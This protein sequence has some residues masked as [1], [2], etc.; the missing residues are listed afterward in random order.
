[1]TIDTV[2]LDQH[3]VEALDR[4]KVDETWFKEFLLPSDQKSI[5]RTVVED[6]VY[7]LSNHA[8]ED[9]KLLVINVRDTDGINTPNRPD[10]VL[11]RIVR[12][13]LNTFNNLVGIPRN[14]KLHR[15]GKLSSIF[16]YHF[17]IHD[18][19][20]IHF[21]RT[22]GGHLFV[23]AMTATTVDIQDVQNPSALYNQA[24]GEYENALLHTL[25]SDESKSD[26]SAP[27]D[28][29]GI[30]FD[31]YV[32]I[33]YVQE[34]TIKEWY[35]RRLTAQQRKFVDADLAKPIRLRGSAGTGKTQCLAIK[36]LKELFQ[37]EDEGRQL[38]VAFITHSAG[39]AHDAVRGMMAAL[40]PEGRLDALRYAELWL[41]SLYELA[42]KLL[43]YEN[44]QIL[45]ISL[46]GVEGRREQEEWLELCI[47][48]CVSDM[49]FGNVILPKCSPHVRR[50][51][52]ASPIDRR[53]LREMANE[54]ACVLDANGVR[55]T[56]QA[57][58][59]SYLADA[60]GAWQMSLPLQAD[61]RAVL[62]IHDRYIGYLSES[63]VIN[64]DQ[65]I[66]DLAGY[67][68][69]NLWTLLLKDEGFDLI[70]IDELHYFNRSERMVFH[71]LARK[72]AHHGGFVPMFMA[73]DLKQNTEDGFLNTQG[74]GNFFRSLQSGATD[75]VE[76]TEVFRSTPQ[77]AAFLERIDGAFPALDL[78]GEWND[79]VGTSSEEAGDVPDLRVFPGNVE[80]IDSIIEDA[81]RYARQHGGRNVA[82][83]CM[84][85]DMFLVFSKAG[86]VADSIS[87]VSSN[88][89][90]SEIRNART[91]C[92]FSMPENVAGLQFRRV[93]VIN[94]DRQGM[95]DEHGTFGGRRRLLSRLYLASSR[96]AQKLTLAATIDGGGYSNV[97]ESS[98]EHGQLLR[99]DD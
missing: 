34:G 25:I 31:D 93:Y 10:L 71:H 83:L 58:V 51:L 59:T 4:A 30:V 9:S 64:L 88:T 12:V 95:D 27:A 81:R 45:P 8:A 68:S 78:E 69:S 29:F 98:L 87:I 48:E 46:D 99:V 65:M 28:N 19:S 80:M 20:R 18:S 62:A 97:L 36:C 39:V 42:K 70:F 35:D 67:L 47:E 1:M 38:R 74:A 66:A 44:K 72:N 43:P 2:V 63:D 22:D 86:R 16:A 73:Y 5:R 94:A 75:L 3:A 77:I 56:N 40:D 14:Y 52:S 17:N 61:R 90:L 50:S 26:T 57:S 82:V 15:E 55:M 89:D 85:E 24:I 54:V 11:S 6:V 53:F 13:A 41:G 37:A 79:Y 84:S 7:L 23:Y 96:A 92:V 76:L 21:E 91:R 33:S 49:S 60:R 32:G